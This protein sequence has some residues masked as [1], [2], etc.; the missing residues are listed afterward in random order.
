VQISDARSALQLVQQALTEGY[1]AALR[2]D[3]T[4]ASALAGKADAHLLAARSALAR[5][6]CDEL[7]H[8]LEQSL[9][10]YEQALARPAGLGSFM[11]RCGVRHNHACALA[12]AGQGD[13][14]VTLLRELVAA[15][16]STAED[17]RS[18]QDLVSLHQLPEFQALVG[19][20]L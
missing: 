17:L 20:V 12:L 18:D 6:A 5:A 10:C 4:N 2:I 9:R 19:P 3:A 15:R 13:A 14:A 8:H 11:E 1:D 7:C 16:G